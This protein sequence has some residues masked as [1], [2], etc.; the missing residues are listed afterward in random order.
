MYILGYTWYIHLN[1]YVW[2]IQVYTIHIPYIY[3]TYVAG[4]HMY[5]IYHTYT[6]HIP[7]IGVPDARHRVLHDGVNPDIVKYTIA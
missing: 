1:T 4:L 2:Y 6:I 5:G 7:K 3:H